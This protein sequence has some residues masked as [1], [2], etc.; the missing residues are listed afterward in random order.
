MAVDKDQLGAIRADESYTLEQFKKLQG[1][2]KDG[3]RSA[4]QA[5]LKVRRAH[6]R[7]FILGS[8]WL[9]YLS[10]QPTN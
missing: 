2:G 4:R 8:D 6:R 5:G 9:E 3:L 7:A 10:N 1:I